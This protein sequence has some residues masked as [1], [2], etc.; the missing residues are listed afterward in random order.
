ML[1]TSPSQR[2]LI[3]FPVLRNSMLALDVQANPAH[4]VKDHQASVW[5]RSQTANRDMEPTESQALLLPKFS[6]NKFEPDDNA[7]DM[8]YI[9]M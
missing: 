7:C 2:K 5:K 4:G 1:E 6:C 8:L 3:E 9:K